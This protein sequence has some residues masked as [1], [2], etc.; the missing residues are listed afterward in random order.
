MERRVLEMPTAVEVTGKEKSEL[1][2]ALD[3]YLKENEEIS[4]AI[5]VMKQAALVRNRNRYSIEPIP[6]RSVRSTE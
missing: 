3:A 6:Y 4:D 5:E 2:D 1:K